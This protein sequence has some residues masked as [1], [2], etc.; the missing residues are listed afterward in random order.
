MMSF[1][2]IDNAV[3]DPQIESYQDESKK[4]YKYHRQFTRCDS[5]YTVKCAIMPKMTLQPKRFNRLR[6]HQT[7]SSNF[8]SGG[9]LLIL[10][11]KIKVGSYLFLNIETDIDIFPKVTIGQVRYC[12]CKGP[13]EFD[14]GLKFIINENKENHFRRL[15]INRLH[16]DFFEYDNQKQ[17]TIE[18]KIKDELHTRS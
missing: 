12:I 17:N 4:Y 6:W 14:T 7:E 15:T 9:I 13:F 8:S 1:Y 5:N 18:S 16:K 11:E 3:L 2:D 10:P